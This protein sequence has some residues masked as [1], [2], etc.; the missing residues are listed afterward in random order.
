MTDKRNETGG[1]AAHVRDGVWNV[2]DGCVYGCVRAGGVY[3][4]TLGAGV[5]RTVRQTVRGGVCKRAYEYAVRRWCKEVDLKLKSN[6]F[7]S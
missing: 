3:G 4:A 6:G 2:R 5:E 1:N 7:G